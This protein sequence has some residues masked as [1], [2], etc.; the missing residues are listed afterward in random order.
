MM[1]AEIRKRWQM[2]KCG[3]PFN[4]FWFPHGEVRVVRR[5]SRQSV[6]IECLDCGR[7]YA[8][9]DDVRAILPWEDVAFLYEDEPPG[10]E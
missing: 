10:K 8:M 3:L 2:F 6:L 4:L 5:L 1:F 9:N 7:L